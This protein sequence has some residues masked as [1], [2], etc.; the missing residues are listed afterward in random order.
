[1]KGGWVGMEKATYNIA[2]SPTCLICLPQ[3]ALAAFC[4]MGKRSKG[5]GSTV[6]AIERARAKIER[7]RLWATI[8][9]MGEIAI[10]FM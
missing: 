4:V 2:A 10:F 5:W 6:R 8:R 3:S 7:V 1:M 9:R